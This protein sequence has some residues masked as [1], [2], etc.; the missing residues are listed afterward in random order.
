MER[1][2]GAFEPVGLDE[3]F[4]AIVDDSATLPKILESLRKETIH[5]YCDQAR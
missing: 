1:M 4:A 2:L 5:E 3:G